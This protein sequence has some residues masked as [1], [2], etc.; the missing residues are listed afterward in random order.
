M[1][2]NTDRLKTAFS[3]A[4]GLAPNA[5]FDEL[6]YAKTRGWDSV[7]HMRL[8]SEIESAFDI[9]LDT[10]DVIGM[11]SFGVA[12]DIVVKYGVDLAAAP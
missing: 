1:P 7:A 2:T 11:S 3:E 12:K 8:V 9:M 6:E 10:D 5:N 4:L